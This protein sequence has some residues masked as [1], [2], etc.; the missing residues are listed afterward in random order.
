MLATMRWPGLIPQ[1]PLV[2]PASGIQ[3]VRYVGMPR[4]APGGRPVRLMD[5]RRALLTAGRVLRGGRVRSG[6]AQR[7]GVLAKLA[8]VLHQK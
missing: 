7:P 5:P 3:L 2:P 1:R 8:G 4:H 6:P